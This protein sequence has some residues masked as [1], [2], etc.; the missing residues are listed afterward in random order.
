M[1]VCIYVRIYV[2]MYVY[3]YIY[4]YT[5]THTHTH[6]HIHTEKIFFNIY[7]QYP[8]LRRENLQVT[9]MSFRYLQCLCDH[10]KWWMACACVCVCLSL[11]LSLSLCG[12]E[13]EREWYLIQFSNLTSTR[14]NIIGD[15]FRS[16]DTRATDLS[17]TG[18]CMYVYLQG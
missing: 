18:V 16:V 10:T 9:M 6:T 15:V 7:L 8:E 13:R 3:I 12:R 14:H 5:H 1:C 11:S 4:I 2:C 17:N